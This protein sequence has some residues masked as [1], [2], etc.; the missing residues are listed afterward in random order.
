MDNL[1]FNFLALL[2]RLNWLF[3]LRLLRCLAKEEARKTF[4]VLVILNRLL[5][6][7]RVLILFFFILIAL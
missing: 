7:L 3:D 4:P 1:E 2:S 6:D 5:I